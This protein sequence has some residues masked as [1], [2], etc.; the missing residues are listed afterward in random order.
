MWRDLQEKW[1]G[2]ERWQLSITELTQG[3]LLATL[4]CH[5]PEAKNPFI[6]QPGI[7]FYK[8]LS[9]W[10][11]FVETEVTASLKTKHPQP[12]SVRTEIDI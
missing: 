6:F 9:H 2:G 7:Y 12:I 11:Y 8:F 3:A 5:L 4:T 10:V 1:K